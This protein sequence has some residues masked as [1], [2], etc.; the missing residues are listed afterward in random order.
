M[1]KLL[2]TGLHM[3]PNN[4]YGLRVVLSDKLLKT[5]V[6]QS[7]LAYCRFQVRQ[8]RLL[9]SYRNHALSRYKRGVIMHP[10]LH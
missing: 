6:F 9:K 3:K 4:A 7:R 8:F 10:R 5:K 1:R 2:H